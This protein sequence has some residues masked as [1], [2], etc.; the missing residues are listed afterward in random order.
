MSSGHDAR[1]G[2]DWAKE[3]GDMKIDEFKKPEEGTLVEGD[4]DAVAAVRYWEWDEG[5]L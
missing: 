1:A 3:S 2:F 5:R 4:A